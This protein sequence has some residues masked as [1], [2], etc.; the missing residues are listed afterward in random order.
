MPVFNGKG[1]REVKAALS[2]RNEVLLGNT[3]ASRSNGLR[4]AHAYLF[5]PTLRVCELHK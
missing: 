3:L 5:R 4:L 1:R 2:G